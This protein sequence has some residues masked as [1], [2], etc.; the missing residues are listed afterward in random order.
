MSTSKESLFQ[1]SKNEESAKLLLSFLK[2]YGNELVDVSVGVHMTKRLISLEAK[3]EETLKRI[4]KFFI[5]KSY[6]YNDKIYKFFIEDPR[7]I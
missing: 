6:A 2:D 7:N 4:S 1:N 5:R 3:D